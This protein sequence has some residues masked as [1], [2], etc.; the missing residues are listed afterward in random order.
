MILEKANEALLGQALRLQCIPYL[1]PS[2][3]V[4][5]DVYYGKYKTGGGLVVSFTEDFREGVR[6]D[7]PKIAFSPNWD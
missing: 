4:V 5:K 2:W 3:L 1:G 6:V 7:W